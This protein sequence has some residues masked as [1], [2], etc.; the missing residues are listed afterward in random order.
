MKFSFHFNVNKNNCIDIFSLLDI[1]CEWR[2]QAR[3]VS[4]V[5]VTAWRG[6]VLCNAADRGRCRTA[7]C[8]HV[9]LQ[10]VPLPSHTLTTNF[11]P[12]FLLYSTTKSPVFTVH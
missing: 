7:T 4:A 5:A 1:C 3:L 6:A 11:L 8:V 12:T 9:P 10:A 2:V